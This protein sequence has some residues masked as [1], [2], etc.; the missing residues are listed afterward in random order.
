M[1]LSSFKGTTH[2]ELKDRHRR[3]KG[4]L[5]G[6]R[7]IRL[8]HLMA[9]GLDIEQI[10][11]CMGRSKAAIETQRSTLYRRLEVKNAS[12]AVAYAIR[13]QIIE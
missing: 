1:S 2:Y 3:R 5:V 8:L 9:E 12:H 11:F 10:A 6:P 13:N 4:Q 7:D